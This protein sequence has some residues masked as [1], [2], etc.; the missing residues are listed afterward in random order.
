MVAKPRVFLSAETDEFEPTRQVLLEQLLNCG[1]DVVVETDVQQADLDT[2]KRIDRHIR[3]CD[4]VLH[5]VGHQAGLIANHRAVQSFLQSLDAPDSFL[6]GHRGLQDSLGDCSGITLSQ[7]EALLALH[8]GVTLLAYTPADR[9]VP[10]STTDPDAQQAHLDRL[11]KG[12]IDAKDFEDDTDLIAKLIGDLKY[13]FPTNQSNQDQPPRLSETPQQLALLDAW[14]A[15][16]RPRSI[17]QRS[18]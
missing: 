13:H 2:I 9:D 1:C 15:F 10:D 16:Q 7:W 14:Q 18:A 3:N 4:V 11:M 6:A 12:G 5:I 17:P 8:H